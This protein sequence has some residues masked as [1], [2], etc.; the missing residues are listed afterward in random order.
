M[1]PNT[2]MNAVFASMNAMRNRSAVPAGTPRSA[3]IAGSA[4]LIEISV[5]NTRTAERAVATRTRSPR[6]VDGAGSGAALTAASPPPARSGS[7]ARH[8]I[9]S[10]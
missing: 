6:H 7:S 2:R 10:K 8:T 3:D 5:P 9:R 1:R 4:P